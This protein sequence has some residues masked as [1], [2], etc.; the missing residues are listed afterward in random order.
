MWY[1][2]RLV[3]PYLPMFYFSSVSPLHSLLYLIFCFC[4]CLCVHRCVFF[5]FF[6]ETCWFFLPTVVQS[7]VFCIYPLGVNLW[8]NP[9]IFI[10]FLEQLFKPLRQALHHLKKI[11]VSAFV[12]GIALCK[13]RFEYLFYYH[14]CFGLAVVVFF[15]N[16][17][18][19]FWSNLCFNICVD[20][21]VEV[22]VP[23]LCYRLIFLCFTLV[24]E[25]NPFCH[26]S[27]TV[28]FFSSVGISADSNC[29]I[30]SP[31]LPW[32]YTP[33]YYGTS[34]YIAFYSL[35]IHHYP[36]YLRSYALFSPIFFQIWSN[37]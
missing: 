25:L 18:F 7:F 13:V 17:F 24:L 22:S 19:H 9:C 35:R 15:V 2:V 1:G 3:P 21:C 16:P 34:K 29:T 11:A 36:Y 5:Y 28:L 31:L 6:H 33:Q 23:V 14:L 20:S 30:I 12:F 37:Y 10:C 26:I 32:Q 4:L 8:I 27:M